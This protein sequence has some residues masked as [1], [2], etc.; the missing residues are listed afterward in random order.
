MV[1][2][3]ITTSTMNQENWREEMK[4]YT[5]NE[6]EL[7]LLSDGPTSWMES[8]RLGALKSRYNKIMGIVEPEPPN[9]QSSFK[10]W[11][12]QTKSL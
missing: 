9:C 8:L 2:S 7:R 4:R 11:N 3:S 6:V 10:K 1:S 12:E 5:T